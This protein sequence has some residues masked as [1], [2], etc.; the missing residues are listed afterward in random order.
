MPMPRYTNVTMRNAHG[1]LATSLVDHQRMI[2]FLVYALRAQ[3]GLDLCVM[4]HLWIAL[5]TIFS[6]LPC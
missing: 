5:G 1:Q 6:W 3:V 2:H 4:F